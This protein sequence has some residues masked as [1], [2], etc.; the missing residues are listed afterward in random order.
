[1]IAKTTTVFSCDKSKVHDEAKSNTFLSAGTTG[2]VGQSSFLAPRT[3][4]QD[5]KGSQQQLALQLQ[6]VPWIFGGSQGVGDLQGM[7][8]PLSTKQSFDHSLL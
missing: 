6:S 8:S 1:V 7:S 4:E 5:P 3:L 2:S